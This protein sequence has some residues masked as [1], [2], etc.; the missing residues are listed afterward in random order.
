MGVPELESGTS[1]LSGMRSNQLSYT[2]GSTCYVDHME[3]QSVRKLETLSKGSFDFFDS[4]GPISAQVTGEP[5]PAAG[6]PPFPNLLLPASEFLKLH[7][8]P[9]QQ[10]Q[11]RRFH[12][13]DS[14][15]E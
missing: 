10:R 5:A 3:R 13:W 15:S 14:S 11:N 2:P 6:S 7:A 1:S 4:F 12:C 9:A 8:L